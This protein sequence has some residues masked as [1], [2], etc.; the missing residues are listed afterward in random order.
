[1]CLPVKCLKGFLGISSVITMLLGLICFIFSLIVNG[2]D[3]A[4]VGNLK[5]GKKATVLSLIILGAFLFFT[6]LFGLVGSCKKSGCCLALYNIGVI[7]FMLVFFI[8]G[9]VGLLM[10]K[11]VENELNKTLTC[12]T[13]E[14]FKKADNLTIQA[15]KMLCSDKCNCNAK[16][17]DFKWNPTLYKNIKPYVKSDGASK[18]QDCE[19]F[20]ELVGKELANG[21]E[22]WENTF[23][24]AGACTPA[25]FY[26]FTNVNRGE[27]KGG[28][29]PKFSEY[30]KKY[31]MKIGIISMIIFLILFINVIFSFCLCCHPEKKNESMSN[32]MV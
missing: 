19:K 8:I 21:M 30:L 16:E 17:E 32:R 29:G 18:V 10:F 12:K 15:S 14:H 2:T 4:F 25:R 23:N 13:S 3:N 7:I 22:I 27:P 20:N 9:V 28:C 5:D 6:G 26:L 24:C 31:S 1:M 11:S